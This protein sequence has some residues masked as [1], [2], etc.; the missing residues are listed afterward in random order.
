[1]IIIHVGIML[2]KFPGI[3]HALSCL[4]MATFEVDV[5]PILQMKKVRLKMI[6][7]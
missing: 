4:T 6:C 1:M 3:L 5:D 7:P 2:Y